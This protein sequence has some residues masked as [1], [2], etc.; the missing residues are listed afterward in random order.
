MTD[1]QRRRHPKQSSLWLTQYAA[2]HKAVDYACIH[3]AAIPYIS[4]TQSNPQ[5]S[6]H[7]EDSAN[8]PSSLTSPQLPSSFLPTTVG[9]PPAVALPAPPPP[10]AAAASHIESKN[11]SFWYEMQ[12]LM[13]LRQAMESVHGAGV[14]GWLGCHKPI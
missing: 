12:W 13:P 7:N 1:P 14:Y 8:N 3:Q 5:G 4:N 11:V 9:L 6:I 2:T 10:A